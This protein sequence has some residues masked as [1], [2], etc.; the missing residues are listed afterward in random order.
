MY[1]VSLAHGAPPL[2]LLSYSL[3]LPRQKNLWAVSGTGNAP[4]A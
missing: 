1:P 3:N 2:E 4:N